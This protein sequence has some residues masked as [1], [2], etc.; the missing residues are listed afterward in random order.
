MKL[1]EGKIQARPLNSMH[2]LEHYA[3]DLPALASDLVAASLSRMLVNITN[4]WALMA[5]ALHAL[6]EG[7]VSYNSTCGIYVPPQL[8]SLLDLIRKVADDFG[9]K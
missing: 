9:P 7:N 5:T 3:S 2:H 6:V 8:Q 1:V 4:S